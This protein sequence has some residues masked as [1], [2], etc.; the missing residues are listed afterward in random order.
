M[1][2]TCADVAWTTTCPPKSIASSALKL[3]PCIPHAF[4]RATTAGWI[5][6]AFNGGNQGHMLG[7]DAFFARPCASGCPTGA[8]TVAFNLASEPQHEACSFLLCMSPLAIASQ[9]KR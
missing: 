7:A 4:H 2:H 1:R 3:R 9:H 6:W 8:S 5:A